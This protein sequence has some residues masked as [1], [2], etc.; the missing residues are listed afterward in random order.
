[1]TELLVLAIVYLVWRAIRPLVDS[2]RQQMTRKPEPAERPTERVQVARQADDAKRRAER[3]RLRAER[4]RLQLEVFLELRNRLLPFFA[5]D[6]A[7]QECLR[8]HCEAR[9]RGEKQ[10]EAWHLRTLAAR[11]GL[12]PI[13]LPGESPEWFPTRL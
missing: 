8:R 6:P 5:S 9:Y 4:E 12:W 11:V 10:T 1:M 2:Y 7:V 13:Y 3:K